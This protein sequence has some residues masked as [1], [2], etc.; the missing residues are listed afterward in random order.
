[1]IWILSAPILNIC[2][3]IDC[4]HEKPMDAIQSCTNFAFWGYSVVHTEATTVLFDNTLTSE[5]YHGAWGMM[6]A[7]MN[8]FIGRGILKKQAKIRSKIALN[9][10]AAI[11]CFSNSSCKYDYLINL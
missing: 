3:E 11:N 9:S 6:A 4:M 7:S 10:I 1:M 5:G 2:T 8:L